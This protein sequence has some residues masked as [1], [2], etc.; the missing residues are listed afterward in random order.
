[1]IKKC[2]LEFL[3]QQKNQ[4]LNAI[5]SYMILKKMTFSA[6]K[7]QLAIKTIAPCRLRNANHSDSVWVVKKI[8]IIFLITQFMNSSTESGKEKGRENKIHTFLMQKDD[9]NEIMLAGLSQSME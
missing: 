8:I 2:D 5:N 1:M 3:A 9:G 7:F 4:Q 6:Q